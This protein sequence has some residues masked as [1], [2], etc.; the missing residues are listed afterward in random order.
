[1]KRVISFVF[2]FLFG[3]RP[4]LFVFE[5]KLFHKNSKIFISEVKSTFTFF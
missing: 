5:V 3:S 2:M 1:M 4:S